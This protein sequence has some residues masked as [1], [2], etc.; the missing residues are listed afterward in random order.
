MAYHHSFGKKCPRSLH[1][2][3]TASYK[4]VRKL[5]GLCGD[6]QWSKHGITRL[7]I[8]LQIF[9]FF[10]FLRISCSN[11]L[12]DLQVDSAALP[13]HPSSLSLATQSSFASLVAET[14]NRRVFVVTGPLMS[15]FSQLY[16]PHLLTH[17]TTSLSV[18]AGRAKLIAAPSLM[19]GPVLWSHVEVASFK[20]ELGEKKRP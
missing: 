12:P 2:L 4:H 11:F 9:I 15:M 7:V 8:V 5:C 16:L 3:W 13:L 1:S 10:F 18:S 19:W 17:G 14:I 6:L 20:M